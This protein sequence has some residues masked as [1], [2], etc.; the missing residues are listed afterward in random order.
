[1]E[2]YKVGREFT[3]SDKKGKYLIQYLFNKYGYA[4]LNFDADSK[5]HA[6]EIAKRILKRF[7]DYQIYYRRSSSGKG[8]HFV[9]TINGFPV[10]L[11]KQEILRLRKRYK[12]CYGR[13][14]ADKIR[15]KQGRIISILF[16]YKNF[17]KAGEWKL[18]KNLNQIRK[19]RMSD[20]SL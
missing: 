12:D 3:I 4:P 9:I 6:I 17:K 7:K 16:D 10:Y 15:M 19:E 14:R 13:I 2:E 18:L 5:K 11:P 20:K 1:M 8:F